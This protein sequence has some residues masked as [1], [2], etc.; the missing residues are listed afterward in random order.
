MKQVLLVALG[1]ALGTV[2]R[3][4]VGILAARLLGLAFPWGTLFVNVAGALAIGLLAARVDALHADTRL[5]IG[6]GVLGGFTTFSTFSLEA[7]RL[8]EHHPWGAALYVASSLVLGLSAC[9][10]G[11]VLGRP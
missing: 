10:V 7:V 9:W 3:H 6:V 8:T 1:G 11:L 2:G 5:F 4:G